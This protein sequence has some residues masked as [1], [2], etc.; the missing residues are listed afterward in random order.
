[1]CCVYDVVLHFRGLIH[2][3][4]CSIKSCWNWKK[5]LIRSARLTDYLVIDTS[6]TLPWQIMDLKP[7]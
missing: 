1:M 2:T 6:V 4:V 7:L 5:P 3:I